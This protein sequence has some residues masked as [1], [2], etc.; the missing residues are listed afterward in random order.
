MRVISTKSVLCIESSQGVY[1]C[2]SAKRLYLSEEGTKKYPFFRP[3]LLY[4]AL[5]VHLYNCRK[6][7]GEYKKV[8]RS[9]LGRKVK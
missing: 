2:Y 9:R 6:D 4:F 1:R 8:C 5:F 3:S 7:D